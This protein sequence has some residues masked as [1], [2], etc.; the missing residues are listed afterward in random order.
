MLIV[1]VK[2]LRFNFASRLANL[3]MFPPAMHQAFSFLYLPLHHLCQLRRF[4]ST[5]RT[6]S[7]PRSFSPAFLPAP[8]LSYLIVFSPLP[9]PLPPLSLALVPL[10]LVLSEPREGKGSKYGYMACYAGVEGLG[11]RW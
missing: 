11:G 4:I 10:T 2:I 8:P 1:I 9:L 7:V 3:K 6:S 5:S